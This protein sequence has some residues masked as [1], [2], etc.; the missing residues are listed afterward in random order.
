M[1]IEAEIAPSLQELMKNLKLNQK[2]KVETE[3]SGI[4]PIG[5]A[6]KN[7]GCKQVRF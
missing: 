7:G 3:K 4:V 6:C 5:T 1:K 2:E